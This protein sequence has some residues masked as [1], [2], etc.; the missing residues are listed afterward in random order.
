MMITWKSASMHARHPKKRLAHLGINVGDCVAFD[1]AHRSDEWIHP[2]AIPGRQG[3]CGES[4][5][6]DQ[7]NGRIRQ[8]PVRSVYFHISNYEEVGHGASAGIP[9]EVA[10]LVT[11]DM[12]VVG[13][14]QE[15]DE[16][17][18]TLCI[19]DSGGPYHEGLE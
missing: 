12:A 5:S 19:K 7:V 6:G 18:A 8:S 15:S 13:E 9:D 10:E 11:V 2:L 3:V 14:G 4:R 16:F 17:H 1:H